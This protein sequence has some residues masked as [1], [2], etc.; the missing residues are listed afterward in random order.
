[1]IRLNLGSEKKS[2]RNTK[3]TR[4]L[5]DCGKIHIAKILGI[6]DRYCEWTCHLYGMMRGYYGF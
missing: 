5:C 3:T 2:E 4:V 1:M 6:K